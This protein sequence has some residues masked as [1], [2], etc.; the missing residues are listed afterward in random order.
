MKAGEFGNNP[1][2]L[3]CCAWFEKSAAGT[4]SELVLWLSKQVVP[5]AI[6]EV[7]VLVVLVPYTVLGQFDSCTD[8]LSNPNAECLRGADCSQET[9]WTIEVF[10][11]C[12]DGSELFTV[13]GVTAECEYLQSS[14]TTMSLIQA[15][16]REEI[17]T[18][19]LQDCQEFPFP[20]KAFYFDILDVNEFHP[21]TTNSTYIQVFPKEKD[22]A[23]VII[24]IHYTDRD[25]EETKSLTCTEVPDAY[26]DQFA[27]TQQYDGSS[28]TMIF[29]LSTTKPLDFESMSYY[30]LNFNITS[31]DERD[32]EMTTVQTIS[33]AVTDVSDNP[34]YWTQFYPSFSLEEAQSIGFSVF[35]VSARDMDVMID[36]DI[37]YS[38]AGNDSN[39]F[40][41]DAITGEL[42]TAK[43][44]DRENLLVQGIQSF[45][46]DIVATEY[47][48][49]DIAKPIDNGS[50]TQVSIIYI[51]DI[52][53]KVPS[54]STITESLE[55]EE[56]ASSDYVLPLNIFVTDMDEG[57]KGSYTLTTNSSHLRVDP[58]SG[59]LNRTVTLTA[60]YGDANNYF[61]YEKHEDNSLGFTI[62]ATEVKDPSHSST[63]TVIITLLPVNDN[64]PVFTKSTYDESIDESTEEGTKLLTVLAN[65]NDISPEEDII[66]Y[67]LESKC[68]SNLEI[69]PHL[70][71]VS[72]ISKLNYENEMERV[73]VCRVYASDSNGTVGGNQGEATIEITIN[74]VVDEPPNFD[75]EVFLMEVLENTMTGEE[76]DVVEVTDSDAGAAMAISI[77]WSSSSATSN[78][79]S[80]PIDNDIKEWFAMGPVSNVEPGMYQSSVIVGSKSP[81]REKADEII[82]T[83][84]A[85]DTNTQVGIS[86][87][88]ATVTVT[89]L[90]ENDEDPILID[91]CNWSEVKENVAGGTLVCELQVTDPDEQDNITLS[92][93]DDTLVTLSTDLVMTGEGVPETVQVLVQEKAVIDREEMDHF[94]VQITLSDTAGHTI[95]NMITIEIRDTNDLDPVMDTSTCNA[96]VT[97]EVEEGEKD[98]KVIHTVSTYDGDATAPYNTTTIVLYNLNQPG[99]K[100][101]QTPFNVDPGTGKV[102]VWLDDGK[103]IID[104]EQYDEWELIFFSFDSC[105]GDLE[106]EVRQ[107]E[108]CIINIKVL[109]V[110]DE[111]PDNFYWVPNDDPLVVDELMKQDDIAGDP[112][113]QIWAQD[114]DDDTTNNTKLTF[115][116]LSVISNYNDTD[117]NLFEAVTQP[118]HKFCKLRATQDFENKKLAGSYTILLMAEDFG[119]PPLNGTW[120]I[121]LDIQ[122][123]N[124]ESPRFVFSDCL[125]ENDPPLI[126]ME[127]NNPPDTELTCE[128]GGKLEITVVDDDQPG[129][130]K[131]TDVSLDYDNSTAVIHDEC[132][133]GESQLS[134]FNIV[135]AQGEGYTITV[136][137][138]INRE[139]G[140]S[141]NLSLRVQ[142]RGKPPNY[143]WSMIQVLVTDV[144]EY[145]PHFCLNGDYCSQTFYMKENDPNVNAIFMQATDLDNVDGDDNYA[146]FYQIVG[147]NSD[148]F[149]LISNRDNTIILNTKR[150]P[151]GMDRE[152]IA[153]YTLAIDASNSESNRPSINE[154]IP[155]N[156]TLYLDIIVQDE[157]DNDPIFSEKETFASFTEA[158]QVDDIISIIMAS[159]NDLNE[160]LTYTITSS[161]D[162]FETDSKPSGEPF[163]LTVRNKTSADLRLD[164]EPTGFSVGYCIFTIQVYD[165]RGVEHSSTTKAKV[166]AITKEFQLDT[167]FFNTV[168]EIQSKKSD[169]EA[170]FGMSFSYPCEIDSIS[171]FSGSDQATRDDSGN[172]TVTITLVLM[173][174]INNEENRPVTITEIEG[175]LNNDVVVSSI[176]S[177]LE[178]IDV[179]LASVK[180][181][182][183]ST[184]EIES[185]EDEI[186]LLKVLLGVVSLVLGLLVVLL[187]SAYYLRTRSLERKVMVLSTNTFGSQESDLNRAGTDITKVPGSN[188]FTKEGANPMYN[189][190]DD[191][192]R[193][194]DTNSIS[195]GDSVLVGVEDNPEFKSAMRQKSEGIE[196][197][198]FISNTTTMDNISMPNGGAKT[199]PL[200]QLS[201]GGADDMDLSDGLTRFEMN[202]I[203]VPVSGSEDEYSPPPSVNTNFSFA[204]L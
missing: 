168:E 171:L 188:L 14:G 115:T 15:F 156:Y 63:L 8:W 43:E 20:G 37:K 70:G 184:G 125:A 53:N 164:F 82:L 119:V 137:E 190:P 41:M 38:I 152:N 52:N 74:D 76:L 6:S 186:L 19:K 81:D 108:T 79:D 193:K 101:Q 126:M 100:D 46:L 116:V 7:C 147:G 182:P 90:D 131:Q 13:T 66:L 80:I 26:K 61:D 142:D 183:T 39:Y 138:S 165:A 201:S 16:D 194:G 72:L 49:E 196:N 87:A 67:S 189:V 129:P 169:I 185:P 48:G 198:G 5:S 62:T 155:R 117:L 177:N 12:K 45:T 163:K 75:D 103:R 200:L 160:T 73:L 132:K 2:C 99:I 150:Y 83:I 151:N 95:Q 178:A 161:F 31:I 93:D 140:S 109:D 180:N 135:P 112:E 84:M 22:P 68:W 35:T 154:P 104:R 102:R 94:Q 69:D 30:I 159:D 166:Y 36:N 195:S 176:M 148:D 88:T 110:N 24:T 32:Y 174:F 121:D 4:T 143:S 28:S 181:P 192:F 40:A 145:P 10:E 139:C 105:E 146:I 162:W 9:S 128:G 34:P 85:D 33:V 97:V 65:D 71:D 118:D 89:I 144:Q 153:S 98:G 44:I 18:G 11:D 77:D 167:Y 107:S 55:M 134:A 23:G 86:S 197:N 130:N 106:C 54:F 157:N 91:A 175:L 120:E 60:L 122:D 141:Y 47:E 96:N 123:A 56:L 64:S 29:S 42:T 78:G 172:G 114:R 127:E 173:H 199:N 187:L 133:S 124:D 3:P 149:E 58:S 25:Y 191:N 57:D 204:K 1:L 113:Y 158:N 51:M 136:S 179:N 111:F 21:E 50:S 203:N 92:I 202:E 59:S 27:M 17:P 170:V